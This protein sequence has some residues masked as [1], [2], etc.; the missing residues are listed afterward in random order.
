LDRFI[1]IKVLSDR[2]IEEDYIQTILNKIQKEK[3]QVGT[4][5]SSAHF[6]Y[7]E[8]KEIFEQLD[9]T[10]NGSVFS[11]RAELDSVKVSDKILSEILKDFLSEN[12]IYNFKVIPVE[13]LGIIYEQFLGKVV[14]TTD[15]RAKIEYKQDIRKAGGVYYTPDY[16]VN[17]IVEKTV[18]EKLKECKKF[19]DLLEIKICDPACGS[20]SFLLAAFDALIKWTI[21]YYK[22]KVKIENHSSELKGLSKEERKLVYLDHDGDVRLTSKIK[23]EILK[24]CIYGVDIDA[25][26]VEVTKMSLS[27][28]ALENT[29]HYEIHNE[30][31]FFHTTI[32][33][34]LEGNIKC[35]NSLV[36][37]PFNWKSEFNLIFKNGGFD[38][39]IGNPPYV[40]IQTMRESASLQVDFLNEVYKNYISGNYDVYII[41]IL[42][43]YKLL[44]DKGLLGFILPHKFFQG[45]NGI[46]IRNYISK[47][48]CLTRVVDFTTNQVFENATTYTC[49]LFLSKERND[50]FLYKRFLLGEDYKNLKEIKFECRD[51]KI[52][53]NNTWNF[54]NDIIS[55]ILDKIQKKEYLFSDITK[56]IFKGSSTGNDDIYLLK[57]VTDSKD[58]V[59]VYSKILNEN[60]QIE[61]KILKPFLYGEDIRR[62]EEIKT[63]YYLLFPYYN[64][65]DS[66]KLIPLKEMKENF[67]RAFAYLKSVQKNLIKRKIDIN[68][69]NFY[70]YSAARSLN[71][72]LQPKLLIPDMLVKLRV[73]YDEAGQFYHGAAIH[74]IVFNELVKEL[75]PKFFF[76]ILNSKLFWFFISNTSTALR[77]NAYRLTPEFLN[78]FKFPKMNLTVENDKVIHNKLVSLVTRIQKLKKESIFQNIEKNKNLIEREIDSIDRQID[79]LVYELYDLT[80]EE[81]KIVEGNSDKR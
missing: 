54:S 69:N 3:D 62:Y 40:R 5:D 53:N 16:I 24:S 15:K 61:K 13:I 10:Y 67:P 80:P 25:Q 14:V 75:E 65:K 8:C 31:T 21:D 43:G 50:F 73:N 47:E 79:S 42:K 46:K 27:L 35:G 12:S 81:I 63:N 66:N 26:A 60:I 29:N 70:K 18:G 1:F 77:G 72:Y 51:S 44:N 71:E 37:T 11:Q 4:E 68:N 20:G 49:L 36:G 39:V 7:D 59:T 17:Y 41:F 32:L 76:A 74:S 23:R 6:V 2:E 28:K 9:K 78:P 64:M 55:K 33:P 38:C 22:S 19:E 52:L 30:R 34:T 58:I 45:E 57:L 56:K 48:K